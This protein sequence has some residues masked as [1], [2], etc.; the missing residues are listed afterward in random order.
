MRALKLNYSFAVALSVLGAALISGCGP[1]DDG[2]PRTVQAA[3]TVI[4]D[5]K[6][7]EGA[8]IVFMQESGNY[9]ARGITDSS[10]R[11]SLDAYESKHG[12]V[13]GT[14]KVTVSKT[15]TVDKAT[16]RTVAKTLA[17]DAQHAAEADAALANVSWVND[18]PDKYNNPA[19]SGLTVAIPD[20]GI[21][22][23]EIVVSRKP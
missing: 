7:L 5:G 11:F 6:P 12:A 17:D 1:A 18:L 16:P 21:S 15:V 20:D 9:F 8:S 2:L 10:G 22:N 3:G 4:C 13:P 14:Y 19:S 23:I